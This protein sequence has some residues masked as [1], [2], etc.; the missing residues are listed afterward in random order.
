MTSKAKLLLAGSQRHAL[1]R[2]PSATVAIRVLN[3]PRKSANSP[4]MH[5]P[6]NEAAFKIERI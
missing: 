4:G 6:K 3:R 1:Q 2:T 5:R